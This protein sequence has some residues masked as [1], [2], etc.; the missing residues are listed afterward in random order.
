MWRE[1][2]SSVKANAAVLCYGIHFGFWFEPK[3][4]QKVPP[5]RC[6]NPLSSNKRFY[7]RRLLCDALYLVRAATAHRITFLYI[8]SPAQAQH[9]SVCRAYNTVHVGQ[10]DRRFSHFADDELIL[11][12]K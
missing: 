4:M 6:N 3:C 11:H 1:K 2:Q 12:N 9:V 10:S 7:W 8:I 5:L